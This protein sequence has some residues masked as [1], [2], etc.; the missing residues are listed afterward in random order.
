MNELIQ[1]VRNTNERNDSNE[2]ISYRSFGNFEQFN[3]S[4]RTIHK[5]NQ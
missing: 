5:Q 2:N 4:K 1:M 3:V